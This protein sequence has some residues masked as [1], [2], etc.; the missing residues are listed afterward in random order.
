MVRPCVIVAQRLGCIGAEEHAA[1]IIKTADVLQWILHA[2]L[3]VL[4]CDGVGKL[5]R[6]RLVTGNEHHAV[7]LHRACNDLAAL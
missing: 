2:D 5:D 7:I 6:L 1:C 3:Q 4:R